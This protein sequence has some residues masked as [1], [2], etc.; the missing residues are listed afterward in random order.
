MHRDVVARQRERTAGSGDSLGHEA[1]ESTTALDEVLV[2]DGV[3]GRAVVRRDVAFEHRIGDFVVEVE[4]VA[5]HAQLLNIHLL[6][7]RM[8]R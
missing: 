1:A 3:F 5:Q 8:V 2:F 7:V 6:Q 4:A